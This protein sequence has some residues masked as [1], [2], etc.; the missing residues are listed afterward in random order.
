MPRPVY[1]HEY[2]GT[3]DER[4]AFARAAHVRDVGYLNEARGV[5]DHC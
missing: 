3:P 5:R 4:A 1:R 2:V